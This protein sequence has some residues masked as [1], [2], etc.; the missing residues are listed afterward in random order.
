MSVTKQLFIEKTGG[1]SLNDFL[2]PLHVRANAI[3]DIEKKIEQGEATIKDF[4]SLVFMK[5]G[6]RINCDICGFH[7]FDECICDD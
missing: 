3:K 2:I 1:F 7:M 6:G 5:N 4:Q